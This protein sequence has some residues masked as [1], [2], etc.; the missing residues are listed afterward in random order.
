LLRS[1]SP[2][3]GDSTDLEVLERR[4]IER[5]MHDANGNKAE[6]S[7]MLGISRTGLYGRLGKYGVEAGRSP[8]TPPQ[9]SKGAREDPLSRV[10]RR[11]QAC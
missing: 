1:A 8:E 10:S 9:S 7:R 11:C 6:A 5:V 2:A 3:H 4:A